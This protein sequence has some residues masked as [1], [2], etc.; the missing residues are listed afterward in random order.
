MSGLLLSWLKMPYYLRKAECK[1][2]PVTWL[3]RIRAMKETL[4]KAMKLT[5]KGTLRKAAD[6]RITV[7]DDFPDNNAAECGIAH[8]YQINKLKLDTFMEKIEQLI[9]EGAPFVVYNLQSQMFIKK[10]EK[11]DFSEENCLHI[12]GPCR[13]MMRTEQAL[14][15]DVTWITTKCY[16]RLDDEIKRQ[17]DLRDKASERIEK[18]KH[19]KELMKGHAENPVSH[20]GEKTLRDHYKDMVAETMKWDEKEQAVQEEMAKGRHRAQKKLAKAAGIF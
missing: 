11:A 17:E 8:W 16:A 5:A 15:D 10:D 14:L 12:P 19:Q 3:P 18:L 9:D 20:V 13:E 6:G 7:N 4:A 1:V 2:F